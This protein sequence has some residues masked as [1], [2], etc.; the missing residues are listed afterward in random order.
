MTTKLERFTSMA[1]D[2]PQTRLN[3][4]MGLLT[5][6]EGLR[7]SFER[8]DGSKAPRVDERRSGSREDRGQFFI[9]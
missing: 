8:Q 6:P 2:E 1:R 5:E 7:E 4:L 3:A 9:C